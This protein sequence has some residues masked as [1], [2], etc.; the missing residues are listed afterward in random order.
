[1]CR[2]IR[3]LIYLHAYT[4]FRI[5]K[6]WGLNIFRISGLAVM[7]SLFTAISIGK[8]LFYNVSWWLEAPLR[9]TLTPFGT[10]Q[11]SS[12]GG[13]LMIPSFWYMALY[14][15]VV[16]FRI[17]IVTLP[18]GSSLSIFRKVKMTCSWSPRHTST[19]HFHRSEY[20]RSHVFDR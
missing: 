16:M 10:F 20:V 13:G 19:L 9:I 2:K 8:C 14:F 1:M 4:L 3:W 15:S 17:T 12:R 5:L 11:Q 6:G 7:A 18:P